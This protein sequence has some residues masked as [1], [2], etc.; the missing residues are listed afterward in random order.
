[1]GILTHDY[2]DQYQNPVSRSS[3]AIQR[4]DGC[5]AA[6]DPPDFPF[7]EN[8]GFLIQMLTLNSFLFSTYEVVTF[9]IDETNHYA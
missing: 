6:I 3:T 9:M 7:N 2:T 5:I 1:M 4:S 8:V